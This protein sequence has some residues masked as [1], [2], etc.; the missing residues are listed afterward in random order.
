ML[1]VQ[2]SRQLFTAAIHVAKMA[3]MSTC[4][5]YA[6]VSSVD[7]VLPVPKAGH[8]LEPEIT[9]YS[10][11]WCCNCTGCIAK[12]RLAGS[13]GRGSIGGQG[14][15]HADRAALYVACVREYL[16]GGLDR[17]AILVR[18]CMQIT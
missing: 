17:D 11:E 4:S 7:A 16:L 10:L 8:V 2:C 3:E 5:A 6:V 13:N 15:L 14:Q 9:T 18:V 12:G 1:D